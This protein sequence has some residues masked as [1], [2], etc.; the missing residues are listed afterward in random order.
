MKNFLSYYQMNSFLSYYY[1]ICWE[2]N[3]SGLDCWV[4]NNSGLDCWAVNSWN[5]SCWVYWV[6]SSWNC[7]CWVYWVSNSWNYFLNYSDVNNSEYFLAANILQNFSVQV[8]NNCYLYVLYFPVWYKLF[9][10]V[11]YPD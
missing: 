6:L 11:Y 4:V 2:K 3:S 7:S 9:W 8:V 5:Y 1:S 10:Y